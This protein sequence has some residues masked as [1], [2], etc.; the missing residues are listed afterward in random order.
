MKIHCLALAGSGDGLGAS[1]L[2]DDSSPSNRSRCNKDASAA[3]PRPEALDVRKRRRVCSHIA[4][5]KRICWFLESVGRNKSSQFRH[6]LKL[7]RNCAKPC[8]GYLSANG[9]FSRD[10]LVQVDQCARH[11][12]PGGK[13]LGRT[14]VRHNVLADD[15]LRR[16]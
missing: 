8:S 2:T 10:E 4:W 15:L 3:A 6:P 1:G 13:L 14:S 16:L 12:N 11:N 9:S 7:R 5:S